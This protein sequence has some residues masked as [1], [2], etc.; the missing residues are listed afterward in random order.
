MMVAM[1]PGRR[2]R[3]ATLLEIMLSMAVVLIGML[4]L[5]RVLSVASKGAS[6]AQKYNQAA[7]RGQQVI[8]AMRMTPRAV[9]DCLNNHTADQWAQCE[10]QCLTFFKQMTVNPPVN[11]V[12][13]LVPQA[14][15]FST[16]SNL[17]ATLGAVPTYDRDLNGQQY[18]VV[19]NS[20]DFR[21]NSSWV[22]N[23]QQ[24]RLVYEVQVTI[25]WK[26]D[27]SASA[28]GGCGPGKQ[29]CVTLRTSM[30]REP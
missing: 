10:A 2:Q 9:L 5:F 11:G 19:Y 30:Y 6:A 8:E 4:A 22:Q 25:G 18:A 28:T 3:G 20:G 29:H 16:L 21:D 27:G 17:A 15:V 14:C 12:Q 23:T 7:A 26:D 24:W 13:G 1:R